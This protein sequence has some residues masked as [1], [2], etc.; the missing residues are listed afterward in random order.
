VSAPEASLPRI[1]L[2]GMVALVVMAVVAV[3]VVRM[4]GVGASKQPDAAAVAVRELR[5]QDRPDGG[6]DVYDARAD[7][8]IDTVEPETNG[9]IRGTLRGLSRE[10]KRV[11]I[12]PD[13]PYRLIARADGRLTLEDPSTGRRVDLESFGPTNTGAFAKFLGAGSESR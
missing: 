13:Q 4:T 1:P 9:F 6:V 11:G 7:R 8:L 2:M 3:A 12:A 5:F 10:R